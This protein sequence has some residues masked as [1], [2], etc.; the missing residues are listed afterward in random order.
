MF[1][2]TT[3]RPPLLVLAALALVL[4]GCAA[5]GGEGGSAND[6][7]TTVAPA[8]PTTTAATD[9]PVDDPA[10]DPTDDPAD[11]PTDDPA[12]DP[13]DDP[14]DD[15][16]DGPDT[17]EIVDTNY[18]DV[19]EVEGAALA[20]PPTYARW[21]ISD[22]MACISP[23]DYADDEFCDGIEVRWGDALDT[24]THGNPYDPDQDEYAWYAGSDVPLCSPTYDET[25]LV[26]SSTRTN[27]GTRD[28]GGEQADFYAWALGCDNG[29]DLEVFQWYLPEAGLLFTNRGGSIMNPIIVDHVALA[30]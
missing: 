5:S 29:A 20:V 4:G 8:D 18:T 16:A 23:T 6:P 11:D 7:T 2:R 30:P 9:D 10:D 28:V 26:S 14:S 25:A 15:P 3:R 22:T 19:V 27:V 17:S 12:D 1:P 13:A 24:A 21:E